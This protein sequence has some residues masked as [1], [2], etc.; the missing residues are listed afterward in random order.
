MSDYPE[1]AIVGKSAIE[2]AEKIHGIKTW[3]GD[4]KGSK[5]IR[6]VD[7]EDPF[8]NNKVL[9]Y[10]TVDELETELKRGGLE[11]FLNRFSPQMETLKIEAPEIAEEP[12]KPPPTRAERRRAARMN[13]MR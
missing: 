2:I 9:G 13:K 6:V 11:Q 8:R 3:Y 12:W 7:K 10:T 1:L 5:D 4:Y